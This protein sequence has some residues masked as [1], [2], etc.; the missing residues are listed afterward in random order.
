MADLASSKKKA[1]LAYPTLHQLGPTVSAAAADTGESITAYTIRRAIEQ[2]KER[3]LAREQQIETAVENLRSLHKQKAERD[4]ELDRRVLEDNPGRIL[5]FDEVYRAVQGVGA[6][7]I[8]VEEVARAAYGDDTLA[9]LISAANTLVWS[10][11]RTTLINESF[12]CPEFVRA[13]KKEE[14]DPID[15]TKDATPPKQPF[16]AP[17][18]IEQEVKYLTKT[19]GFAVIVFPRL[20]G[21]K[22]VNVSSPI[23]VNGIST[24]ARRRSIFEAVSTLEISWPRT[25]GYRDD[26][27]VFGNHVGVA[28][29]GEILFMGLLIAPKVTSKKGLTMTWTAV[30]HSYVPAKSHINIQSK[31]AEWQSMT[32]LDVIYDLS[33]KMG[34]PIQVEP[35]AAQKLAQNIQDEEGQTNRVNDALTTT[36]VAFIQ[37]LLTEQNVFLTVGDTGLL[38]ATTFDLNSEAQKEKEVAEYFEGEDGPRGHFELSAKYNYGELARTYVVMGQKR[39]IDEAE[40]VETTGFPL[41]IFR[42]VVRPYT[43]VEKDEMALFERSRQEAKAVN[44]D[45]TVPEWENPA[46]GKLW[47]V[48]DMVYLRSSTYDIG[49][50]GPSRV[51]EPTL[52]VVSETTIEASKDWRRTKLSLHHPGVF[53]L[54]MYVPLPFL[55]LPDEPLEITT[56]TNIQAEAVEEPEGEEEAPTTYI[57]VDYTPEGD[58][59]PSS[60]KIPADEYSKWLDDRYGRVSD[61]VQV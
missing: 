41:P 33:A 39:Q 26:V 18:Y 29:N 38:Y 57:E 54:R 37:K 43:P 7:A 52:L 34:F 53:S 4:R 50:Y 3:S 47:A 24:L 36:P 49:E 23:P 19:T 17:D 56:F 27:N 8:T 46:T 12:F 16:A 45:L 61:D 42:N 44:I 20:R 5:T 11:D 1:K 22:G 9:A 14:T 58:A 21:R 6:P 25:P 32:P 30:S 10:K 60:T 15:E 48:G 35:E 55:A 13:P 2:E 28:F 40:G 31:T 51:L 59:I